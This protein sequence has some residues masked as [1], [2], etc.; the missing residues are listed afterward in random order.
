[1]GIRNESWEHI[2]FAISVLAV[3]FIITRIQRFVVGR[4]F[5]SAAR[6]LNVDHT[7]YNFFKN[8]IDFII[9]LVALIIIF[10]SIPA[11][12]DF[13]MTLGA[14]AGILAA[15]VG[16]AS[17]SAFSNIISGVFLVIFKPFRVGD[18]IKVGQHYS[19]DVED[20]TLRHT[21]IRDFENKRVV[22]PNNVISNETIINATII[23]E[24]VCMFMELTVTFESNIDK[25]MAV[26]AEE[27]VKNP[28]CIDNRSQEEAEHSKPV[29][30]V[31]V[32]GFSDLGVQLRADAW[33]RNAMEGF[34]M[35]CGL[36]KSYK[37]RFAREGIALAFQPR[38]V[39][40][41]NQETLS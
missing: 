27:A 1:M 40:N 25:T 39:I 32:I 15:I 21:V 14:S 19:G 31:R 37:E 35:K 3:A 9:F 16:F 29:V 41:K 24:K 30:V 28:L 38:V 22:I 5:K 10:W 23:D 20:I 11:L 17:Q 13:G 4:F 26:M 34:E 6:K 8:A 12:H 36:Y 33:A 18:R 7:R 2:V